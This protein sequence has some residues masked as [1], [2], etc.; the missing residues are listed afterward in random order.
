MV[1]SHP[2]GMDEI[3]QEEC[4]AFLIFRTECLMGRKEA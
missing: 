4:S 1:L 3:A 2:V